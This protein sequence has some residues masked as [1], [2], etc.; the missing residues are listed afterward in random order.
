MQ[1]TRFQLAL[2]AT[3]ALGL[4]LSLSSSLAIGYPAGSAVSYGSNPVVA[5][6][7]NFVLPWSGVGEGVVL[8]SDGGQDV[9][10]TE[11]TLGVDAGRLDC[12]LG[13]R[14]AL[15]VDGES[16]GEYYT[17]TPMAY[18]SG[19]G[20]GSPTS[21]VT[22]IQ[23]GSGVRVPD[24]ATLSIVAERMRTA[25]YCYSSDTQTVYYAISGYRAQP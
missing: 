2:I 25:G 21:E 9:V 20:V 24:G 17:A 1:T 10:V 23:M 15:Q 13:V 18:I 16:K 12:S 19:Y 6:G 22:T 11:V 14:Y 8:S 3:L 5:S 7:G 4:G